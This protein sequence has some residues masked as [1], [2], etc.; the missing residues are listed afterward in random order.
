MD[1]SKY[2]LPSA[3]TGIQCCWCN[4][5]RTIGDRSTHL[6][7]L[8]NIA[9]KAGEPTSCT[10]QPDQLEVQHILLPEMMPKP[11]LSPWREPWYTGFYQSQAKIRSPFVHPP[12]LHTYCGRYPGAST[13]ER[14]TLPAHIVLV[15]EDSILQA[16]GQAMTVFTTSKS[17]AAELGRHLDG[18]C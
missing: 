11:N 13:E 5:K 18:P 3:E 9:Q 4:R 16:T 15:A 10:Q 12:V 2:T 14:E 8:G 7:T 17:E 6:D 1:V